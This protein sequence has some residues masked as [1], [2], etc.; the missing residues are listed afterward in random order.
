MLQAVNF[1]GYRLIRRTLQTPKYYKP[2]IITNMWQAQVVQV[3]DSGSCVW[4][5]NL[6]QGHSN[7]FLGQDT[8]LHSA[9]THPGV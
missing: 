7:V 6:N 9:S 2:T 3:L 4:A 1:T 8:S 5:L